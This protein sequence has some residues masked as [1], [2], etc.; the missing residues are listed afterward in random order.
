LQQ[1]SEAHF[2]AAV[3]LPH[4]SHCAA[5]QPLTCSGNKPC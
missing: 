1:C 5:P 3:Q 4:R 2:A